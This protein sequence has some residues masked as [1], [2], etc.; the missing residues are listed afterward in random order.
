MYS[1][2][3]LDYYRNPRNLGT[4]ANSDASASDVNP[5]CGDEVKIF[6]KIE[7]GKIKKAQFTGKGCAISQAAASML[8]EYLEGKKVE[9]VLKITKEKMLEMLGIKVVKLSLYSY[10]AKYN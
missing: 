8:C 3:I 10:A 9:E 2:I 7:N 4:I 5:L 6:L 1:E